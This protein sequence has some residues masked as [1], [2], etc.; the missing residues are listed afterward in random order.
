M[1]RDYT[2]GDGELRALESMTIFKV[3]VPVTYLKSEHK[4]QDTILLQA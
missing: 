1:F 3:I 2:M 4:S